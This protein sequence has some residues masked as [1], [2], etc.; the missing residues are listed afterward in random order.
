MLAFAFLLTVCF[1]VRLSSL[2]LGEAYAFVKHWNHLKGFP[3][4]VSHYFKFEIYI[5]LLFLAIWISQ[6]FAFLVTCTAYLLF[7]NEMKSTAEIVK[8]NN[9]VLFFFFYNS[10][11]QILLKFRALYIYKKWFYIILIFNETWA[12][13]I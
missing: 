2:S 11:K 9:N 3:F 12:F 10:Y 13:L 4:T 5:S 6:S 1:R 8:I 7:D